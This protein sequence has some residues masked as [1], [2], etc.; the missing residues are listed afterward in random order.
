MLYTISVIFCSSGFLGLMY[1]RENIQSCHTEH[2]SR[3]LAHNTNNACELGCCTRCM[4]QITCSRVNESAVSLGALTAGSRGCYW[5]VL[6]CRRE[7]VSWL[8]SARHW[9]RSSSAGWPLPLK[10]LEG[11][12]KN[13]NTSVGETE[14]GERA[15]NMRDRRE[16]GRSISGRWQQ[17]RRCLK[18]GF[19]VCLLTLKQRCIIGRP[20]NIERQTDHASYRI[21]S[22]SFFL[23][24]LGFWI[25]TVESGSGWGLWTT[26]VQTCSVRICTERQT[27]THGQRMN[28]RW[29]NAPAITTQ[30]KI[31]RA[32]LHED[33]R[34]TY[35]I[36]SVVGGDGDGVG[37][38]HQP[39]PQQCEQAVCVHD[40]H[41]PSA[42][43]HTHRH[44]DRFATHERIHDSRSWHWLSPA[45]RW[46]DIGRWHQV[47]L[48]VLTGDT[49]TC[50]EYQQEKLT[51]G[52]IRALQE[53]LGQRSRGCKRL[54][55]ATNL[56]SGRKLCL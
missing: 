27:E 34:K 38:H 51:R 48:S 54:R 52:I 9:E 17:Q 45:W 3:Q 44:M 39:L 8:P 36:Q 20:K 50:N 37:V 31:E 33:H 28:G 11:R 42:G 25:L 13:N 47:A 53:P 32:S 40:L 18:T 4:K 5:R 6:S 35:L 7:T 30:N 2:C 21:F 15:I 12:K 41:L 1:P 10:S 23:F 24:L 43:K 16:R 22:F 14:E 49:R 29:L 46:S 55:L 56:A 26:W 19:V